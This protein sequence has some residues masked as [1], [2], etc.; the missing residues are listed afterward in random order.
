MLFLPDKILH[1]V[2]DLYIIITLFP[3]VFN[4]TNAENELL[5]NELLTKQVAIVFIPY[6]SITNHNQVNGSDC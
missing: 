4:L 5:E 3:L 2:H 6:I 1:K